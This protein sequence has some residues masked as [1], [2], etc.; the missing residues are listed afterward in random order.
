MSAHEGAPGGSRRRSRR[1]R[2][3]NFI[4]AGVSWAL[5]AAALL[6]G[7]WIWLT[8][9]ANIV[10]VLNTA[11]AVIGTA[12]GGLLA[13]TGDG[14]VIIFSGTD[15]GQR[16]AIYKAIA[17]AFG[18]AFW[19]MFALWIAYQFQPAWRGDAYLHIGVLL[20]LT[21]AI[22]LAGYAWRRRHI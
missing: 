18:A 10:Y 9:H 11:F 19:G 8:G 16:D 14:D 17:P 7:I 15:E 21:T 6:F 13:L 5:S 12:L 1:N 2:S 20:I 22:Y 4:V 3:L